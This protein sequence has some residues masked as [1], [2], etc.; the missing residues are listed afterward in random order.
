MTR[1]VPIGAAL[2]MRGAAAAV[3][4]ATA[5]LG[6]LATVQLQYLVTLQLQLARAGRPRSACCRG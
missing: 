6:S 5:G 1:A 4:R 2:V 3:G